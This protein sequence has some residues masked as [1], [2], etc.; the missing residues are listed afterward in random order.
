MGLNEPSVNDMLLDGKNIYEVNRAANE[1]LKVRK[2]PSFMVN[3]ESNS[4]NYG[5]SN[6]IEPALA[7][8]RSKKLQEAVRKINMTK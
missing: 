3:N 7:G 2:R 1:F 8:V 4:N 6:R 5:N